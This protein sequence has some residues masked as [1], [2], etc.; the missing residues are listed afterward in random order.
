MNSC[1]GNSIRRLCKQSNCG[2][3]MESTKTIEAAKAVNSILHLPSGDQESLLADYFT[4]PDPS[5][6]LDSDGFDDSDLV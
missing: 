4:T 3:T 1:L 5:D 6:D 2:Y